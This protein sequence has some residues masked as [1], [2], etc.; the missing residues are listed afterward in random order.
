MLT[1]FLDT[2][3]ENKEHVPHDSDRGK[4]FSLEKLQVAPGL[5]SCLSTMEEMPETSGEYEKFYHAFK[6]MVVHYIW[7]T[8]KKKKKTFYPWLTKK[9]LC[10]APDLLLISDQANMC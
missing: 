5:F 6:T 3:Q 4:V 9:M 10:Y 7:E 1:N 8:G 2:E